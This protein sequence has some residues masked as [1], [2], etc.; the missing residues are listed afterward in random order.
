[1]KVVLVAACGPMMLNPSLLPL[2][3]GPVDFLG[4]KKS[5]C[6]VIPTVNVP[7]VFFG[8]FLKIT[9]PGH[10]LKIFVFCGGG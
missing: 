9:C 3:C 4:H 1:M 10:G 7:V 6:F 8:Q 2:T 5:K